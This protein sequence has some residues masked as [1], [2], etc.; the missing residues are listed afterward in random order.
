M[1]VPL[2]LAERVI[3]GDG[4]GAPEAPEAL[5]KVH[6]ALLQMCRTV[7]EGSDLSRT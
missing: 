4:S 6:A 7:G 1:L 3:L 5:A 2:F